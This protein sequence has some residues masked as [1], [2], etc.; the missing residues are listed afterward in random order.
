MKTKNIIY[1][2]I[3]KKYDYLS[4]VSSIGTS[5]FIILNM[6]QQSSTAQTNGTFIFEHIVGEIMVDTIY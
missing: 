1:G 4:S 5:V 3:P 6:H 2:G